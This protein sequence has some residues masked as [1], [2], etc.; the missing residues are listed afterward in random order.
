[1]ASD[2]DSGAPGASD[3]DSLEQPDFVF[4][5]ITSLTGTFLS[6]LPDAPCER[7]LELCAGTGTAALAA[8]K[9]AG[10]VW[11]T[12]LTARSTRFAEFNARLNNLQN[13]TAV[14]GDLYE[15]VLGLTFDRIV[16]H[17]PY[18]PATETQMV[19]RD[20]GED[21]EQVIR[22]ILQGLP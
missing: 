17:P 21:G 11:A 5:A 9:Q 6:Q 13:V 10:H 2:L 14:Q 12:D 3:P 4:S 16:A 18:V 8:A 22:G 1:I 15:P 19:Y 7:C 20:G